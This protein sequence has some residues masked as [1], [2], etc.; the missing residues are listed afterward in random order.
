MNL[1]ILHGLDC[2][3]NTT[4][5]VTLCIQPLKEKADLAVCSINRKEKRSSKQE[6]IAST[7][8]QTLN[9]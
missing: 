5:P 4:C 2:S 3:R 8:G 7:S 1:L 6:T 9:T